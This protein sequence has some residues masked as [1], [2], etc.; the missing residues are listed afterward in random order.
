[1]TEQARP[2]SVA[3]GAVLELRLLADSTR[4]PGRIFPTSFRYSTFHVFEALASSAVEAND[5]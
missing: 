2:V 3:A 5:P 1:M 4:L